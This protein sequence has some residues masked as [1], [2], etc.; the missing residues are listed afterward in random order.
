MKN[1]LAILCVLALSCG[2]FGLASVAHAGTTFAGKRAI[3]DEGSGW[4]T[5]EGADRT[6]ERIKRAGFNVYVPC[7]WHGRGTKWPSR[8]APWDPDL[9]GQSKQGHDS[10]RYLIGKAHEAG[11]EVHP[12]FTLALRQAN[13]FPELAPPG[14]PREAFDVHDPRVHQLMADLIAEVVVGY[15][16]DG[17]NLD[18]AR[19]MGL[20]SSASCKEAYQ[21]QYGRNLALDSIPFRVTPG[22]VPSLMEFQ[23]QAVTTM[24][25]TI[26]T[27][28][29][30]I[31][32][33]ALISVDVIP[34]VAGLDQGQNSLEWV[35]HGM[36]DVLF[37]MDYYRKINVDLTDSLRSKLRNP[38]ALALLI[39]NVSVSEEMAPDQPHFSRDGKWLAETVNLIHQQWPGTGVGIYLFSMLSDEQVAALRAGPFS[40]LE[41][42][43]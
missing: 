32:P 20:C 34:G 43:P 1:V 42:R 29:R 26:A 30:A 23:A 12:W 18:Y 37:R 4:A 8:L 25:N 10:L 22:L 19:T 17:V 14:T 6:I 9:R 27:R 28:V 39:S 21:R 3:F 38:D 35:N 15:D 16:V 2:H 40:P 41:A 11:I 31:K 33:R 13:L 36:V 7:V 24:V 5:R